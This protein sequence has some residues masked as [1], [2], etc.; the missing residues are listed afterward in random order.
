L[1]THGRWRLIHPEPGVYWWHTPHGHWFR[2]DAEGTHHH[3]R[4]PDL[5]HRWLS[6]KARPA[7]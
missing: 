1:K 2:V 5:D 6:K 4:D 3:G 7:A